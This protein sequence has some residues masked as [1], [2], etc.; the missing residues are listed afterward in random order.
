MKR[1]RKL[2]FS[3]TNNL[4]YDQRMIRICTTLASAGYDV[5]LI[6]RKMPSSLPLKPMPYRQFRIRCIFNRGFIF[7]AE[8]NIKLFFFLLYKKAD[9]L[10][11]IDLDTILPTYFASI[12]KNV[13][14]VYDAHELFCEMKEVISR[15]RVHRFWKS[16]EKFS[17]PRYKHGYTVSRQISAELTQLYKVTYEI[18]R[19]L[20]VSTPSPGQPHPHPEYGHYIIYQGAVNEGRSFETLIPAM[21]K[22]DA[23]LIIC[24]DGNFM[25]EAK[26]I[27]AEN[28]L[29]GK[30]I[31]TGWL[32]PE[33]LRLY[34]NNARIGVNI[35]ERIGLNQEYSLANRFFDYIQSGV[36]QVCVD[37]PAYR[38]INDEFYCA[39]LINDTKPETISQGIN[40]LMSDQDLYKELKSNCIKAREF[41]N[42]KTEEHKLLDFYQHI[43]RNDG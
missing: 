16:V 7:Y 20:P 31:F 6:G 14:R 43:F 25:S 38:E 10:C 22:V 40:L 18:I 12:I 5:T 36:P 8:F 3:V 35:I 30:V 19:N 15:P 13:P 34:T 41:L 28:N 29:S 1:A 39:L 33:K 9:L 26:R 27:T 2:I 32:E 4:T 23:Y 21:K 37:Y 42:W 24:G 17:V 11:A